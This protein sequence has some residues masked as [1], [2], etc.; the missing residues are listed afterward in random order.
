M[1][2]LIERYNGFL[3]FKNTNDKTIQIQGGV[4]PIWDKKYSTVEEAKEQIREWNGR[5]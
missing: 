3:L 5:K 1:M 2:Q 4:A